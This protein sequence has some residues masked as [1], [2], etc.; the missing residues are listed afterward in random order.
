MIDSNRKKA[1]YSVFWQ[2]TSEYIYDKTTW[3]INLLVEWILFWYP[4]YQKLRFLIH[5]TIQNIYKQL[6]YSDES[7][8]EG[9]K[10]LRFQILWVYYLP[11]Q[12]ENKYLRMVIFIKA[13]FCWFQR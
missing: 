1:I 10:V 13:K 3:R 5:P 7:D 2:L 6:K 9:P 12:K 4:T 8:K 11:F